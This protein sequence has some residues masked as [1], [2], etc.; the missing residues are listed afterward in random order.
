MNPYLAMLEEHRLT[1]HPLGFREATPIIIEALVDAGTA[2]FRFFGVIVKR[3]DMR[4]HVVTVLHGFSAVHTAEKTA[5][6]R[7]HD[8]AGNSGCL[9]KPNQY[10]AQNGNPLDFCTLEITEE[11]VSISL[12]WKMSKPLMYHEAIRAEPLTLQSLST[13][14]TCECWHEIHD[15]YCGTRAFAGVY[16]KGQ[17]GQSGQGWFDSNGRLYLMTGGLHDLT[18]FKRNPAYSLRPI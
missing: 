13:S 2:R 10:I 18:V 14:E 3:P 17:S 4:P 8:A 16:P 11:T 7:Y 15:Q 9:H 5:T 12:Q 1:H 6:F